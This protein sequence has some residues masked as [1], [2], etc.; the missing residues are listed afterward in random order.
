L[1]TDSDQALRFQ[2][3][4]IE[5][6]DLQI[7]AALIAISVVLIFFQDV[8]IIGL[9]AL[10]SDYFNYVLVLPLLMFYLVY[11]KRKVLA[12]AFH[13]KDKGDAGRV[14]FAAGLSALA[15]SFI[16]YLYGSNTT[17]PLDYHLI[18]LQIFLGATILI[19]FNREVLKWLI[20]PIIL[21][22]TALPSV[23]TFGLGF[24]LDMS[25]ASTYTAYLGL[26]D[27]GLHASFLLT[28]NVP[29]ITLVGTNGQPYTFVV[30]V[31]SSGI[32]SVVGFTLFAL[33]VAYIAKGSILR[34]LVLFAMAYPL[35]LVIN[36]MREDIIIGAAYLW[37]T[38]VFNAFHFSSG[39]VLVFAVTLLLLIIGEKLFKLQFFSLPSKLKACAYCSE[40]SKP[41]QGFCF[42]C[43][44][45]LGI[46][47]GTI[48][49]REAVS[50]LVI[51]IAVLIFMSSL[52]P[53][54][55]VATTPTNVDLATLSSESALTLLPSIH[56][57]NLSFIYRDTYV[58]E[59]LGQDAALVYSYQM[60]NQTNANVFAT[61]QISAG[62]HTPEASLVTHPELS[63]TPG[64]TILQDYDIPILSNPPLT[65]RFFAYDPAS[66]NQTTVYLYWN[67][68]AVFNLGSYSDFRNIQISLIGYPNSLASEGVIKDASDLQAMKQLLLPLAQVIAGFWA[69]KESSSLI[70][71]G[72]GHFS[73]PLAGIAIFPSVVVSGKA[74]LDRKKDERT[75]GATFDQLSVSSDKELLRA[76]S[77]CG[78]S[79]RQSTIEEI[80]KAYRDMTNREMSPSDAY[81]ALTY[82]EKAGLVAQR[83]I[84]VNNEPKL[85]WKIMFQETKSSKN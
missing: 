26:K 82:A 12:A 67:M 79:E 74:V 83:I 75:S 65:G 35:L 64:V 36:I 19:L 29:S 81:A 85:I 10:G 78:S 84:D 11:R 69:P 49:A 54:V 21:I 37:G 50:I 38:A 8:Y 73:L 22:S 25:W 5:G 20:F 16:V 77:R 33:F 31:A 13:L 41:G 53:A 27:M 28:G 55:A 71:A 6:L 4:S 76:V 48:R 42:N 70:Q 7:K 43:G 60:E 52:M 62:L 34:K 61:V 56:G 23:V 3:F 2:R 59:A 14:N 40:Q 32:Y 15:V 30:G 17:F 18:A 80:T 68:R 24:W 46:S 39:I 58:Q 1:A 72:V 45:F 66:S 63:G 57:W 51:V 44:R 9:D 47:R